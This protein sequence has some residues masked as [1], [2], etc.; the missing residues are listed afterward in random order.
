MEEV[1][2]R[3]A[4]SRSHLPQSAEVCVPY[5]LPSPPSENQLQ[6][7]GHFSHF[8]VH[9]R[10]TQIQQK[11]AM[12]N[13]LSF[14]RSPSDK[15]CDMVKA[16]PHLCSPRKPM[17]KVIHD[18]EIACITKNQQQY[19]V[20]LSVLRQLSQRKCIQ[21][22]NMVSPINSFFICIFDHASKQLQ[23]DFETTGPHISKLNYSCIRCLP[24]VLPLRN[25]L[26]IAKP[27]S[28]GVFAGWS[29]EG[30]RTALTRFIFCPTVSA[31]ARFFSAEGLPYLPGI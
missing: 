8:K 24:P 30:I 9:L 22:Q 21:C 1:K 3:P 20:S 10:S 7:E 29:I 25:H 19:L 13:L 16:M 14:S 26:L 28:K 6:H 2:E 5:H 4:E 31:M 15:I 12:E 18:M 27:I 23:I 11:K 17:T